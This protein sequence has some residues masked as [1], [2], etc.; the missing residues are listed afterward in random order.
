MSRKRIA[1]GPYQF[2]IESGD[3][4]AFVGPDGGEHEWP[5]GL[6]CHTDLDLL[7]PADRV[8]FVGCYGVDLLNGI[9]KQSTT[10]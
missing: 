2:R 5:K 7:P 8:Y 6:D 1:H 10:G 9:E 4:G 3:A